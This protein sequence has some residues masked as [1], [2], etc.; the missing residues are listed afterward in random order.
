MI[1]E[2]SWKW[3]NSIEFT[4]VISKVLKICTPSTT[5][6]QPSLIH[7]GSAPSRLP[8]TQRTKSDRHFH[9]LICLMESLN[10]DQ[11]ILFRTRSYYTL[12]WRTSIF[13]TNIENYFWTFSQWHIDLAVI[14]YISNSIS[15]I[16]LIWN[17][18]FL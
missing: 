5:P 10:I 7:C 1:F 3:I 11:N 2:W 8:T 4:H 6:A 13:F 14:I 15:F 17:L 18:F 9:N 16:C 12:T